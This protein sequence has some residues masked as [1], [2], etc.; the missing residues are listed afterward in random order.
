VVASSDAEIYSVV[1]GDTKKTGSAKKKD[2]FVDINKKTEM[3]SLSV[4]QIIYI[5][6]PHIDINKKIKFFIC[7]HCRV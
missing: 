4:R 6:K 5:L 2:Y 7:D 1:Q 3:Y